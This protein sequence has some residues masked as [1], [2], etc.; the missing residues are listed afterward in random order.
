MTRSFPFRKLIASPKPP[1]GELLPVGTSSRLAFLESENAALRDE[2][3]VLRDVLSAPIVVAPEWHLT[4]T[5]RIVLGVLVSRVIATKEAIMAA[6][7]GGQTFDRDPKIADVFICQLRRRPR[8]YGVTI[9]NV[10]AIG[11]SLAPEWRAR[12]RA[13]VAA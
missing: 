10:W 8:P 9:N 12:L 11:W 7:Y 3:D 13:K 2:V 5:H 1:A 6:L 4:R